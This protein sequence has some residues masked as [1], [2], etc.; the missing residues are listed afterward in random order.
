MRTHSDKSGFHN[1]SSGAPNMNV[2]ENALASLRGDQPR[3][4]SAMGNIRPESPPVS[5]SGLMAFRQKLER[6][7]SRICWMEHT[8][9]CIL[10]LFGWHNWWDAGGGEQVCLDCGK[11]RRR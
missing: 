2:S 5:D 3:G 8:L 11:E 7:F 1:A 4:L 10:C 6:L 9:C